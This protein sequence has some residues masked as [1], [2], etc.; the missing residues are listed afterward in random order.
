[1]YK[2][3]GRC[4]VFDEGKYCF[5]VLNNDFFFVM[6]QVKPLIWIESVIEKHSH[7]RIEYMIKV[8]HTL[9]C[10]MRVLIMKWKC[11]P[12]NETPTG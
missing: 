6:F 3:H 7:S 9:V 10:S 12:N 8:G 2:V 1:M 4:E 11:N 5:V